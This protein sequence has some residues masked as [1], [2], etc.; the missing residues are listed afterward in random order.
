VVLDAFGAL[1]ALVAAVSLGRLASRPFRRRAIPDPGGFLGADTGRSPDPGAGGSPGPDPKAGGYPGLDA[2]AAQLL[3]AVALAGVLV[4]RFRLLPPGAWAAV[5]VAATAW[6]TWRATRDPAG[7]PPG[8]A[9]GRRAVPYLVQAAAL[10]YLFLGLTATAGPAPLLGSPGQVAL[11]VLHLPTLAAALAVLLAAGAVRELD[12]LGP[13]TPGPAA[14]TP[15]TPGPAAPRPAA[16]RPAAPSP[17]G[18]GRDNPVCGDSA[19]DRTVPGLCR[20][21]L[22]V[23]LALLLVIMI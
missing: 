3:T 10:E 17:I 19:W 9:V 5:F 8:A 23:T 11:P 21:A 13:A 6:F 18:P 22:G 20:T 4:P 16:P 15:A 2:D 1:M 14:P 12:R 7:Q